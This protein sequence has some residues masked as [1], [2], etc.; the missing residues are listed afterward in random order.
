MIVY[1][2]LKKFLLLLKLCLPEEVLIKVWI[3]EGVPMK[4]LL[5]E[6]VPIVAEAFPEA[7]KAAVGHASLAGHLVATI[8]PKICIP[9]DDIFQNKI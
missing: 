7:D 2:C 5:P 4:L 1:Y 3:P 8:Q 9:G 6:E